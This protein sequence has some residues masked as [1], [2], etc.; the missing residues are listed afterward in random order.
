MVS[1]NKEKRYKLNVVLEAGLH[2][3]VLPS[4]NVK[5]KRLTR[6]LGE[7]LGYP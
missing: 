5:D 4:F 3:V 6:K 2:A 1:T 7:S